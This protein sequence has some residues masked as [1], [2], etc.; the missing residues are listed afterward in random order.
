MFTVFIVF[1]ACFSKKE[2]IFFSNV[3]NSA[4]TAVNGL[5]AT[6]SDKNIDMM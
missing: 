5:Q 4:Y 1:L 3:G 2:E 6:V